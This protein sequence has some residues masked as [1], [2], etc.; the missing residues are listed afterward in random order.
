MTAVTRMILSVA[1][2]SVC[3]VS[4]ADEPLHRQID[5]L[6]A[7]GFD[8]EPAPRSSDAEFFRRIHLD[9]AGRIPG[10]SNVRGFLD[11]SSPGKRQAVID[12]LLESPA[13]ADRM[14]NLFHVML[15][16]RRGDDEEWYRFLKSCFA[17]NRSWKQITE[18]ILKPNDE[19]ESLRGAAYF[20][21]RRLE[22]VGQQTTDFAGLTRDVGRMF[23]GIDLQC[24]ECHDH[25]FIDDYKQR[26]FQ[27]L[28]S[29]YQNVSIRKEK[30]PAIN[31][32]T[33]TAKLEFV[34]VLTADKGTT[35]PRI[36]FGKEFDVPAPPP[37][38]PKAKPK[39]PDPNEPPTFSALKLIAENLPSEENSLFCRNIVNRLWFSFMGRGLVEPLDAFHSKN[40]ASHPELLDLLSTEFVAH[41]F[42]IKWLIRELV[43]TE[44][45]QRSSRMATNE[46]VPP[47][48]YR[49]GNQRRLSAEQLFWSTL[50]ATGNLERLAPSDDADG[51]EEFSELRADFIKAF[52]SEPKEAAV[53]YTPAVKQALYLLNDSRLLGLLKPQPGNLVERLRAQPDDQIADELYLSIFS[54]LPDEAERAAINEHLKENAGHR[55]AAL[56][57]LA[58]AMLTSMEFAVN[59]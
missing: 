43:Q 10:A 23:L 11:N 1:V 5:Q 37:V 56:S 45:W 40:Q 44:T 48:S 58:W 13:Y 24:A 8:G 35:G 27:G 19:D 18:E 33:M 28:F 31:E 26:D 46:L 3:A 42:D 41:H 49:Q 6:I 52:A 55:D 25:L 29:V 12:Q 57:R 21:S 15:M 7:K 39:R 50:Q 16:E 34:S 17:E 38:D 54:R 9:L 51:S 20:Y 14:A 22:K 2:V 4:G 30:F 32:K 47:E 53:A 59:H 36:P